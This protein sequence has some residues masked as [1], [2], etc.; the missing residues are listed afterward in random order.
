MQW[1]PIL[2]PTPQTNSWKIETRPLSTT[3]QPWYSVRTLAL[4]CSP[5]PP[6]IFCV[7]LSI[8]LLERHRFPA[9]NTLHLAEEENTWTK[10]CS[11]GHAADLGG[12]IDPALLTP[13]GQG[14]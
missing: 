6:N 11:Q 5:V 1:A 9:S 2:K 13:G 3:P 7:V 12:T 10:M 8:L 14:A 4:L